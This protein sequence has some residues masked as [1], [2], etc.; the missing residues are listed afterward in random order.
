MWKIRECPGYAETWKNNLLISNL[1]GDKNN[2]F[3]III[4]FYIFSR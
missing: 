2:Q 1:V 4:Y 3:N